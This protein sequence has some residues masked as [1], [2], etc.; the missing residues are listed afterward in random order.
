MT[1]GTFGTFVYALFK[2]YEPVKGMGS[3][4]QQFEQTHGATTQ[5]FG[6]LALEQEIEEHPGARVSA[7]I[8]PRGGIR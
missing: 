4:Y 5:V 1:T 2:A 8:F 6:F 7:A 3:V